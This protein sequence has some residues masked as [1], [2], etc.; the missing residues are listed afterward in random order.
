MEVHYNSETDLLYL[1]LDDT[2]QKVANR[3]LS[4]EVVLD[5][6]RDGKVVGIEILD[7]SRN[8]NMRGL[9][10]VRYD[11]VQH[12][13]SAAVLREVSTGE[14]GAKKSGGKKRRR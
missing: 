14:W 9:L 11:V 13:A 10:P 4:D 8:L 1:R 7:A 12:G 3:R 5:V 2:P 6:G